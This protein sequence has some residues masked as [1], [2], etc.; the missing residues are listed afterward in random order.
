VVLLNVIQERADELG[1]EIPRTRIDGAFF[2]LTSASWSMSL[3]V[4]RY[5]AIVCGLTRRSD[6][7][8]FVKKRSTKG[9]KLLSFGIPHLPAPFQAARRNPHQLR[10][11]LQLRPIRES[12]QTETAHAFASP[13]IRG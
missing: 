11:N 9:A 7:S 12:R 4:S 13:Q 8:R 1:I 2:S 3:K 10:F 6:I 5:E